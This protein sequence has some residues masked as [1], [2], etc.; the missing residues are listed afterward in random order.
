MVELY[1]HL[2]ITM[3]KLEPIKH[4]YYNTET[5]EIFS[6]VSKYI[7]QYKKPFIATTANTYNT[8]QALG[9]THEEVVQHW[10]EINKLSI[11]RGHTIHKECEDYL[12]TGVN[13]NINEV[14]YD[15]LDILKKKRCKKH[16]EEPVWCNIRALAGTPDL[17]LEYKNY[18]EIWDW[19]TN[20]KNLHKCFKD[21]KLLSPYEH[22]P[23]SSYSDYLLQAKEYSEMAEVKYNKPVTKNIIVHIF[24]GTKII[25]ITKDVKKL[26]K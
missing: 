21:N 20:K 9:M 26:M 18:I 15:L 17:V 12:L 10:K 7:S 23:A 16:I 4:I 13:N 5:G 14:P 8:E 1:I 22:L 2:L 24:E 3:I 25:D 11:I 19:K 6:S